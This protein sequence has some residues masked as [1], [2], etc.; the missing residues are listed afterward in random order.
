MIAAISHLAQ[1]C[2]AASLNQTWWNSETTP[3]GIRWI[4]QG[5]VM[6]SLASKSK[7]PRQTYA[8]PRRVTRQPDWVNVPVQTHP[9]FILLINNSLLLLTSSLGGEIHPLRGWEEGA[10][11]Y[12]LH[13]L[14]P[15]PPRRVLR[16][17]SSAKKEIQFMNLP[18]VAR[19]I[20]FTTPPEIGTVLMR[21]GQRYE[22]L[23]Q[24]PHVRK[25][26]Q[27]TILLVWRS[28]CADCGGV[29]EI[30]TGLISKGCIN[31]RCPKHHSP[32]RAV[33]VASRIRRQRFIKRNGIRRKS[34]T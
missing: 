11:G 9:N 2:A 18:K 3:T 33:T 27:P 5:P 6:T 26:G 14:L 21:E 15:A 7:L 31:R 25:D 28:H 1:N 12:A 30:M 8:G 29:F 22:L 32:G 20:D 19:K 24:K 34:R 23:R 10:G 16:S 13:R 4:A 17:M